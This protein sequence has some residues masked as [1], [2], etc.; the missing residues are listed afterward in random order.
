MSTTKNS[1]GFGS[2]EPLLKI[3]ARL[4]TDPIGFATLR[5][6][7][8]ISFVVETRVP[9]IFPKQYCR[10]AIFLSYLDPCIRNPELRIRIL[11]T[12]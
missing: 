2:Q 4:I 9:P 12:N 5:N 8:S 10:S 6:P 7:P 11:E 3:T 1:L